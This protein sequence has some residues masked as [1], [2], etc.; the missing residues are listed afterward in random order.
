MKVRINRCVP[1]RQ[2]SGESN[3]AGSEQASTLGQVESSYGTT[4]QVKDT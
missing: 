3:P 1:E 2:N 4:V